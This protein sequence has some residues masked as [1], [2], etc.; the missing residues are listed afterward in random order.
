MP[1]SNSAGTCLKPNFKQMDLRLTVI[2]SHI[3]KDFGTAAFKGSVNAK[4]NF[5]STQRMRT[6]QLTLVSVKQMTSKNYKR[7]AET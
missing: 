6:M 2:S 4:S 7:I 5:M 1:I 3:K